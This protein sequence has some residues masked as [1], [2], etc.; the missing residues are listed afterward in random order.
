MKN[1]LVG[2]EAKRICEEILDHFYVDQTYGI[3]VGEKGYFKDYTITGKKKEII[4]A[5][6]NTTGDCW[7][8]QFE[9]VSSAIRWL[10]M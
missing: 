1:Y 2:E 5:F 3:H 4:V 8:E 9:S 7:I 10:T 6:D